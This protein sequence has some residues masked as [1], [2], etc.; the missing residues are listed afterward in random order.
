M[1]VRRSIH[2]YSPFLS[3]SLIQKLLPRT[4]AREKECGGACIVFPVVNAMTNLLD[5]CNSGGTILI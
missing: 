1:T 4:L 5:Q 2:D 3:D